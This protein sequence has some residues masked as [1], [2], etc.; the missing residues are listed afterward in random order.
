[1]ATHISVEQYL[2]WSHRFIDEHLYQHASQMADRAH[3]PRELVVKSMCSGKRFR[4]ML[5]F[6]SA[7]ACGGKPE[8]AVGLASAAEIIHES[9]LFH[10]DVI[11][12]DMMRRENVSFNRAMG[13]KMAILMGDLGLSYSIDVVRQSASDLISVTAATI[14]DIGI[15]FIR[16]GVDRVFENESPLLD[17]IGMKT[18]RLFSLACVYGGKS[19]NAPPQWVEGLRNFGM[20][21]GMSFQIADDFCS[22]LEGL[23]EKKQVSDGITLPLFYMYTQRPHLKAPIFQFGRGEVEFDDIRD[24][25]NGN[26]EGLYLA[27]RKL[28]DYNLKAI[29]FA[30]QL[31]ESPFRDIMCQLPSF[32]VNR[33]IQEGGSGVVQRWND[34]KV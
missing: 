19:A 10:D 9:T 13:S 8:N 25:L 12:E 4:P 17:I 18:G 2:S 26:S 30:K 1:M 28:R 6:L 15:G 16:E 34:I 29:Y 31:P 27:K 23:V 33:M 32:V 7:H 11:D 3:L 5:V 22:L 24:E 20:N 21:L 14:S